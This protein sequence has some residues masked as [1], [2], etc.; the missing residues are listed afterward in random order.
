MKKCM[1][2]RAHHGMCLSFFEGKGY[3]EG[4]TS[5]MQTIWNMMQENPKLQIITEADVICSECPNLENGICNSPDL[6]K[7]YDT[8]VL[9]L[10]GLTENTELSWNE[11]SKLVI[12][13]ILAAG[14]REDICGN[15]EW[16]DICKGKAHLYQR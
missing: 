16:T 9:K 15:C 11:F 14:K 5:H 4:F 13:N 12:E 6:V 1:K 10:C 7:K 2:L 8:Q 3:S